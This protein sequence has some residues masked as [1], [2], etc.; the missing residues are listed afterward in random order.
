MTWTARRIAAGLALFLAL[1]VVGAWPRPG[2]ARAFSVIYCPIANLVLGHQTFGRGGHA[3]LLPLDDV[4][5]RDGDNVTADT[6]LS[7]TV[8]GFTGDLRLGVSLRR[9]AYL[10]LLI[11][12]ALIAASPLPAARRLAALAIGIPIMTALNLAALDL[13]VVSTF[14]LRLKAIYDA[15]AVAR[16][17]LDFAGGAL[18]TPPGNR[19]IAP[20]VLGAAII[21]WQCTR[22]ADPKLS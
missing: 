15:G 3:R 2:A 12:V 11:L 18:L 5:R 8:A 20:L 19:F 21:A 6:A 16:G 1:M 17:L 9:D 22:R 10:P 7:L 4:V 13:L 14:A